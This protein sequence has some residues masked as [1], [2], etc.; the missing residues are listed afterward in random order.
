MPEAQPPRN[1]IE[2]FSLE[3]GA[4]LRTLLRLPEEDSFTA[5]PEGMLW[6]TQARGPRSECRTARSPPRSRT[7]ARTKCCALTLSPASLRP[8]ANSP[9][10]MLVRNAQPSPNG[11]WLLMEAGGC[12]G[13]FESLHLL[14]IN[15]KTG[16][17]WTVGSEATA[18]HDLRSAAW[19]ENGSELVVPYGPSNLPA[20][21]N[22]VPGAGGFEERCPE[23]Q[24]AGL[25]IVQAGASSEFTPNA[26]IEPSAGCSYESAVFDS[27]GILAVGRLQRRRASTESSQHPARPGLPRPADDRGEVV[28]R[29]PLEIGANPGTV[30]SDPETGTILVT[31]D[32]S[33]EDEA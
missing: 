15:L 11:Q 5:G 14:A 33:G 18:C 30:E 26:Q 24:P 4:P 29:L 3:N 32:Q 17:E 21:T 22:Q 20:G 12:T 19:S 28:R 25:A 7:A 31:D 13:S 27:E 23:S 6:L 10:S 8:C 16:A 2:Q 9:S 1:A